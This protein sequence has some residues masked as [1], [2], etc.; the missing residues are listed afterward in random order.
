MK[1]YVVMP[2]YIATPE[3]EELATQAMSSIINTGKDIE[4]ISVNDNSPLDTEFLK[5]YSTI[6]INN[7]VNLGF[8]K[9]CNMGF[10]WILNNT[11]ED[12]YIVCAN[13]DIEVF[14]GWQ[15]AMQEPFSL[16]DN[17]GLTGLISSKER[18]IDGI[19]V[20]KY[21]KKRITEGGLLDYWMESGGFWMTKKSILEKVGLFDEQFEVGGLEDVDLFLRIRDTFGYKIIMSGKSCFWHKEGAT[22]W[23]DEIE[24]G[25]KNKNKAIEEVNYEKF[26]NKWG[27]DVRKEGLRFYEDILIEWS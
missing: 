17:V 9:T 15:E 7:S 14:K 16:F 24:E 27:F 2:N 12:C 3:L 8:G 11:E 23:N 25:F 13:N 4:I 5:N 6:R 19:S 20:E 18:I 10:K 22:R 1:T 26:N 21:Q